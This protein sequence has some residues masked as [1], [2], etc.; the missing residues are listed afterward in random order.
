MNKANVRIVA[1]GLMLGLSGWVNSG[2]IIKTDKEL[3]KK[4]EEAQVEELR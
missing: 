2:G 3:P 1:V 4:T